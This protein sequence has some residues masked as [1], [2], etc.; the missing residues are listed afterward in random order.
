MSWAF[1]IAQCSKWVLPK[2]ERISA[3]SRIATAQDTCPWSLPIH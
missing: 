1:N 3:A 2:G